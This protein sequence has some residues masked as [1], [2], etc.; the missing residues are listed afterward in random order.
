MGETFFGELNCWKVFLFWPNAWVIAGFVMEFTVHTWL[1]LFS[2]FKFDWRRVDLRVRIISAGPQRESLTQRYASMLFW[3]LFPRRLQRRV[4]Q[5][6]LR[7]AAG[8]GW[9]VI[10]CSPGCMCQSQICFLSV[11]RHYSIGLE[12]SVW[13][14]IMTYHCRWR[15][16]GRFLGPLSLS[17]ALKSAVFWNFF[18]LC[19]A[20]DV[21]FSFIFTVCQNSLFN[22]KACFGSES[23]S[24]TSSFRASSPL[25]LCCSFGCTCIW[26]LNLRTEIWCV[27]WHFQ[28]CP[29]DLFSGRFNSFSTYYVNFF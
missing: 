3:I 14:W 20:A 21:F 19:L 24:G 27:C 26:T 13:Q 11:W 23:C 25:S 5:R 22:L 16:Y 18:I 6:S 12:L 29:S 7:C 2:C 9:P 1:S 17:L 10:P 8:P 28:S 15:L 4:G